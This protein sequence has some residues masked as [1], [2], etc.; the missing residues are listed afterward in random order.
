MS[1]FYSDDP[2]TMGY[3]LPEE[4]QHRLKK[5]H[6]YVEFLSHLAQPRRAGEGQEWVPEIRVGE[7][8]PWPA[9]RGHCPIGAQRRMGAG[10][11]VVSGPSQTAGSECTSS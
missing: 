10:P 3:F 6:E 5:L 9:C 2:E 1:K 8:C 4:S 11:T 7:V